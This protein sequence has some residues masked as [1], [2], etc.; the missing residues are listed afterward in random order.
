M[1][2]CFF[3]F[4]VIL[5]FL[6][7]HWIKG[8]SVKHLKL[9]T[10]TKGGNYFRLGESIKN[11][12]DN[13]VNI[14]IVETHGS[15]DN[16]LKLEKGEIDLA[17]VQ[18]DIAFLAENG[19]EPFKEKIKNLTGIMTFYSESI[20]IITN[21]PDIYYLN[22][23][24]NHKVNVGPLG[25]GL[26]MDS[27][28]IL[29]SIRI[30][31]LVLKSNFYPAQVLE[32][33]LENRI[34]AAFINNITT[35]VEN[36]IEKGKLFLVPLTANFIQR[37]TKTYPYF[38]E[39][40][41]TLL[42]RE[43]RTIAVKSILICKKELD[44]RVIYELTKILYDNFSKLRFPT[45]DIL[46]QQ[47]EIIYLMTLKKWHIGARKYFTELGIMK[48]QTYL[49]YL[50]IL[51][52]IPMIIILIILFINVL[53]FSFNKKSLQMISSNSR[54][55]RLIKY[56]NL[57]IFQHKYIVIFLVMLT[58]YLTN[59][60]IVQYLEHNWAIKNNVISNFDN[61]SLI[62]NLLWMFIFGGS[63]YSDNLFPQCP[64][65]KFFATL[66]PL[67]GLGGFLTMVGFLTSD[68][69]KNR[70]L[71]AR[72]VKTKMI[73]NHI[74]LCGW[75]E[76]VPF[77]VKNLLHENIINKKPVVILA[78]IKEELPLEKYDL[79]DAM[80]TYVR[81][82]ATNKADLDRAN[83]K[84]A[85][86][87]IIVTDSDSTEPDAKSILKILTIEK[88]CQELEKKGIRKNRKNIYTIAEI[89]DAN[90]F[91]AAYDALVNEIVL[92]GHIKSKVFVQSVLN[93]GVS[94]FINEILTYNDFNDIYSFQIEENSKLVNLTFDEILIELRK[95]KILLLSIN[96]E[97]Q[98]KKE[99]M[100]EFQ[101]KYNLKRTVITNPILKAELNYRTQSGD[102]L[103]VLA[104]YEKTVD[105][106]RKQLKKSKASI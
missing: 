42:N 81:G 96:I 67:I 73:K 48:S 75:N 82:D 39:F 34:Q 92:L 106:A 74:I 64:T 98:R 87:A 71:E 69:I 36:E 30:W 10:A 99:E 44:E 13:S 90:K 85:D 59:M 52:L 55:L 37:L 43:I 29:S 49:R 45:Q 61:R 68:H 62:K 70:I 83:I 77:L 21:N 93:P 97:N 58:A 17:I 27:K 35:Q 91:E 60:H 89:Q 11:I 102:F 4:F 5:L 46:L 32:L 103:I 50:W 20:Y 63:G 38:K 84:E 8:N 24:A 15:I 26:Y 6:Q 2:K 57:K 100:K 105:N 28:T 56:I 54:F 31:E 76:N 41:T 95:Y 51:S 104:Q 22:Q 12:Y 88:Y 40:N 86:T 7:T 78:E 79:N 19:L 18:N 16:I 47:N 14:E 9:G 65:A 33:L 66:I 23:L 72:G 80:V 53:L 25:S 1:K 101:A 94:K 3:S